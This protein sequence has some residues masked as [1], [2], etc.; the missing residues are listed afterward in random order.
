VVLRHVEDLPEAEV[1]RLLGCSVG[2][3]KSQ[4]ARGL[5]KLRLA[6]ETTADPLSIFAR[7]VVEARS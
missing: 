7:P 3:V 4:S 5:A 1:A 6:L 2:T